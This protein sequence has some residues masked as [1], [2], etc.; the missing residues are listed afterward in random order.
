MSLAVRWTSEAGAIASLEAPWRQLEAAAS[1]RT[2]LVSGDYLLPWYRHYAGRAGRPLVGSAWEGTTL[3]GL[4]PLVVR[5]GRVGGVPLQCVQFAAAAGEAG[6]FLLADGRPDLAGAFLESLGD[7]VPFDVARFNNLEAGSAEFEALAR[8]A[9]RRGLAVET[10]P[11]S[12]AVVDL[13]R[14]YDA[15]LARLSGKFRGNVQ[16][17]ARAMAAQGAVAVEGVHFGADRDAVEGS[18][19]RM[20]AISDRSWKTRRGGPMAEHHRA[21]FREVARSFGARGRLD[22]AILTVGGQDRAYMLGVAERGVYYD[23]TLSF[24]DSIR[25]LAPGVFLTQAVLRRLADRGIHTFVSHGV[26]EYKRHFASALVPR[27]R[28]LVF[29]RRPRARLSRAL[30]FSLAPLWTRLGLLRPRAD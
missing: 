18:L 3:V 14:G 8:S 1:G 12:Y 6:E 7:A 17:R 15:Y 28:A 9:A 4:A 2:P 24:D 22:L 19:A 21:F 30:R 26:H 16:R 10:V 27:Q 13:S 29:T 5:R 20:F 11:T 23:V 25:H